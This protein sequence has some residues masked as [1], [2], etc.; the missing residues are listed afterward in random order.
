MTALA[1]HYSW[2]LAAHILL[3][4]FWV[5][6]LL[7]LPRYAIYQAEAAPGSAEDGAWVRRIASLRRVILTPAMIGVWL[8]GLA[9]ATVGD[10]WSEGWLHAK[11]ALVLILSG[12]HGWAVGL[13]RKL[14]RG[15]R[16]VTT[17]TLR[18][19]NEVPALLVI[20]IVILA[21]VKPL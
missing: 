13:T 12:Y 17:R 20:G 7:I 9:L 2:L 1:N 18:L 21:V 3:V 14:A 6:G 4:I 8:L 19:V 10:H 15:W 5:A 16:P 11:L